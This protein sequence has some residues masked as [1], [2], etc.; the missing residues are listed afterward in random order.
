MREHLVKEWHLTGQTLVLHDRP[1]ARFHRASPS[2]T[3]ELFLR[4]QPLLP[5]ASPSLASFLPP[6]ETPSSTPFT[7]QSTVTNQL[8]MFSPDI[9]L[10]APRDDRTALVVSSTSWTPDE[11]FGMLLEA[12]GKYEKLARE[13]EG[14]EKERLPKM[15]VIVTGK[16]PLKEKY[17]NEVERLQSGGW[18]YVRCVS[19]WLEAEDYPLLLGA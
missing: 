11:D 9:A 3:H 13:N 10:P 12:L 4:L 14:S 7:R 18:K 1:P 17:I 8:S 19:L 15:L 2:E 6:S 16:G 5:S